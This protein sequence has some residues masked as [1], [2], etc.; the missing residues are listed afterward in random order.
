LS[1]SALYPSHPILSTCCTVELCVSF[2]CRNTWEE[3]VYIAK[4]FHGKDINGDGEG[5][6]GLCHFPR[7]GAGYWDWWFSELVY[8]TWATTDQLEGTEQGFLFDSDTL[9]PNIGPGLERGVHIWKD[10]WDNAAGSCEDGRNFETGRCAVGYAPPG[11]WK[12]V[13][14][15]GIG[16]TVNETVVWRP[17]MKSGKLYVATTCDQTIL[18]E[19]DTINAIIP[20]PS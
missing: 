13:F 19:H 4:F 5:D 10:L 18:L 12:S 11:C 3:L 14:L 8:S 7:E 20:L 6:F 15:N 2:Y 16:R 17:Q 9:E 1:F